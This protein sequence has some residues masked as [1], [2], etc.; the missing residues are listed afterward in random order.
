MIPEKDR[1]R[2]HQVPGLITLAESDR[3]G[4]LAQQ[5]PD[6][7]SIVEIGAH[8]GRSTLWL[9]A[10]SRTGAGAHVTTVDPWPDPGY[11]S[12]YEGKSDDDP[13]GYET[14]EGV[15][16]AFCGN[17]TVEVGWSHI[18]ALR[19]ASL[20]VAKMWVNP[21]GLLFLD[22]MHGFAD[23]KADCDAWLPRVATRGIIALHDWFDDEKL[24]Q[25]G[26]VA[27]GLRSSW[28]EQDWRVLPMTDNLFVAVRR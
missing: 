14:G 5:V 26:E 24:T 18:T 4:E 9:A 25:E 12:H 16:D 21:I 10:G 20:D 7:T 27:Y 6:W 13:F 3:L 17:V 23:V 1:E 8:T 11:T 22:A 15:F 19:A 28:N 2:L